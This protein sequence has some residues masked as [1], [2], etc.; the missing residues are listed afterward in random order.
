MDDTACSRGVDAWSVDTGEGSGLA[1]NGFRRIRLENGR[2]LT[3]IDSDLPSMSAL[4]MIS[5]RRNWPVCIVIPI[6]GCGYLVKD[7]H[8]IKLRERENKNP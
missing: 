7:L 8:T 6:G 1:G 2:K 5:L 3:W 4:K